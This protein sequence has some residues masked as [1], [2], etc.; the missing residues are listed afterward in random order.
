MP[1]SD[2]NRKILWGRSGNR[3]AFCRQALIIEKTPV[4]VESVVGEECHIVSALPKGPRYDPQ[5]SSTQIDELDNFILLCGA[6]HKMIDDQF[7][8]YTAELLRQIRHKHETWVETKFKH[9]DVIKPTQIR[10]FKE[11][12]PTHLN[13]VK[14]GSELFGLTS[15]CHG[16]YQDYEKDLTTEEIEIVGSFLQSLTDWADIGIGFEPLAR[17]RAEK[18]IDE[19]L[20][21]LERHGFLVF[22]KKERQLMEGGIFPESDWWVLHI[23]IL[24][25]SNPSIVKS[26]VAETQKKQSDS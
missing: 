23:S 1:I 16:Q 2:K 18:S 19:E 4:D 10:R 11:R 7:E 21:E 24:R 9:E 8:T 20:K 13:L 6:H 17:M 22:A 5:F 14:S 25:S 12:I 15:E 3:C 26:N